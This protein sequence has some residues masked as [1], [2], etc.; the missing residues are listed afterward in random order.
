LFGNKKEKKM[1]SKVDMKVVL[2]GQ[3]NSGKTSLVERYRNGKFSGLTQNTVGAAFGAKVV[4]LKNRSVTLGIWD[5]AGSER[6]ESMTKIYYRGADAA[7]VC[8]DLTNENSF[9]KVKYWVLEIKNHEPNCLIVL[10]GTKFD[11]IHEG[12]K[13]GVTMGTVQAYANEIECL[14]FE[15][16]SKTGTN[17]EEVFKAIAENSKTSS[18][19]G[20]S[21]TIVPK[22]TDTSE[23]CC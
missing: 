8:F 14:T 4:Q 22:P 2:L 10:C 1:A 16:S 5:T 9:E 20:R 23:P 12:S 11:L 7:V 6:Y 18:E 19:R 17:V 13:R 15:T 21:D 3:E